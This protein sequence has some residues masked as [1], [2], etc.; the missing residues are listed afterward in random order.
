MGQSLSTASARGG[1]WSL[2]PLRAGRIFFQMA[3]RIPIERRWEGMARQI[4]E[5][6]R[7]YRRPTHNSL[8]SSEYKSLTLDRR[9]AVI[10]SGRHANKQDHGQCNRWKNRRGRRERM[11]DR[12]IGCK[13]LLRRAARSDLDLTALLRHRTPSRSQ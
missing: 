3:N 4:I 7:T 12:G 6:S 11:L 9:P 13:H 2:L 1:L 5:H 8:W 10:P